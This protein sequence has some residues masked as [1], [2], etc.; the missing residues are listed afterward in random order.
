MTKKEMQR[1]LDRTMLGMMNDAVSCADCGYTHMVEHSLSKAYGVLFAA[2]A[3]G[4]ISAEDFKNINH[5]LAH[6]ELRKVTI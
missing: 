6:T 3:L 2:D 4:L 5:T 1:K